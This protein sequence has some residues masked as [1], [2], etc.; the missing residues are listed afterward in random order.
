MRASSP[1]LFSR[2]RALA[3]VA[4]LAASGTGCSVAPA[5]SRPPA[6]V[7][8]A[9]TTAD[10]ADGG[11]V[12][13]AWW[14]A[15][16]SD[17]LDAL[18]TSGRARNLDLRAA[19][20]RIDEARA[21]AEIAGAPRYPTLDLAAAT[22][23]GVGP[24]TTRVQ[25]ISVVASYEIDFWGKYRA[26]ASSAAAL[27]DASAFDAQTVALTLDATITNT[28]LELLALDARRALA[29]RVSDQARQVLAI[30]E[31][32]AAGGIVSGNEVE[33][34]R[35]AYATFQAAVT[36]I[37]QQHDILVHLLA[38]LTGQ[39]PAR[40]REAGGD[41]NA[42]TVPTV[43]P[44]LPSSLLERRPDVRAAEARL[45]SANCD[46]GAAR[47]AFFPRFTLTAQGGVGS[48]SLAS[49]DPPS[50]IGNILGGIAQPLFAGGRLEGQ[51]RYARAHVTEL[52]ATYR[53]SILS[54]LRDVEDALTAT[55]RTRELEA[56][57]ESAVDAARRAA[58]IARAQLE[59]GTAD[60]LSVLTAERT[61]FQAEDALLQARLQRLEAAVGLFRA[62]GGGFGQEG[63]A[64]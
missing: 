11:D 30:V 20:A 61:E 28:Y 50:I 54:S 4:T 27:A 5:Y 48:A 51:L 1:R 29:V 36:P 17:E 47:A 52:T 15:F 3:A 35:N 39:A 7:P 25:S 42:L 13:A 14:R 37:E 12:H 23:V 9:W 32:Q 57:D 16:G 6:D 43:V 33:Q 63:S 10:T 21:K 49:F 60:F 44:G 59:A 19:V 18:V 8:T 53:Q 31:A 22:N 64:S 34:Q 58:I 26:Q 56:L 55:T 40:F 62:L 38:T 2:L 45:V 24:S 41:L 46:V